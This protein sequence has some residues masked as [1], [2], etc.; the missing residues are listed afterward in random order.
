MSEAHHLHRSSHASWVKASTDPHWISGSWI[1]MEI[2]ELVTTWSICSSMPGTSCLGCPPAPSASPGHLIEH[3]HTHPD[4]PMSTP[5]AG[6]TVSVWPRCYTTPLLYLV[7]LPARTAPA[8]SQ[9][10]GKRNIDVA[11]SEVDVH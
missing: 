7:R 4:S 5:S 9:Q 6:D 11:P 8:H 2:S 10:T 1:L 3:N